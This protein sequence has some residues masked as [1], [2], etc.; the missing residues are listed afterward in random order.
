MERQCKLPKSVTHRIEEA[1]C[2]ARMLEA[3]HLVEN[4]SA[5]HDH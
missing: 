4:H 5:R 2:V 3:D 1:T